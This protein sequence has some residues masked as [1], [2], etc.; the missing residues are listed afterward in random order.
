MN[1]ALR[2]GL[3]GPAVAALAFFMSA[4]TDQIKESSLPLI[5][6]DLLRVGAPV[7]PGLKR[8]P[9]SMIM[10]A[11]GKS[12]LDL[13]ASN[14]LVPP[15]KDGPPA[16][17]ILPPMSVV[18]YIGFVKSTKNNTFTALLMLDGVALAV[19][20]GE[21]F[22]RGW[23]LLKITAEMVEAEGPDGKTQVFA[24]QGERL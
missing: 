9:F 24:R 7:F 5:R 3:I 10:L 18:R 4:G 1:D 22:G 21:A 13:G 2:T 19:S 20:E 8:D 17:E 11:P 15:E 14:P 23:K 16:G 6:H 12:D